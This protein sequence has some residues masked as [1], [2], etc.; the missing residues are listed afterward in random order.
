MDDLRRIKE[1]MDKLKAAASDVTQTAEAQPS[2]RVDK[3]A[4]ERI[5]THA[6]A[7]G[8]KQSASKKRTRSRGTNRKEPAKHRK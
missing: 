7:H 8:Q 6:L 4:A 1:S 5:V 2:L 3:Q